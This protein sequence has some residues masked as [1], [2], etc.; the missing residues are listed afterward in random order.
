MD[1]FLTG[2]VVGVIGFAVLFPRET[3]IVEVLPENYTIVTDI[4]EDMCMAPL[5]TT[6][7]G[8]SVKTQRVVYTGN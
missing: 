4:S 1:Q 8:R 6:V 5:D 7:V 3:K 2:L